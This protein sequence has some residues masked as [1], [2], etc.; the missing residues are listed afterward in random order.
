MGT[1]V[2]PRE[3]K[4]RQDVVASPSVASGEAISHYEE[5]ASQRLATTSIL[6]LC[7]RQPVFVEGPYG[8]VTNWPRNW[9]AGGVSRRQ[10]TFVERQIASP[11]MVVAAM[12]SVVPRKFGTTKLLP[13]AINE[14][15]D[16]STA[17]TN[18]DIEPFLVHE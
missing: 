3:V 5:V 17:R 13:D 18:I 7:V 8:N 16:P 9:R 15:L 14:E 2:N 1:G 4:D 10:V 11:V 6:F 12:I